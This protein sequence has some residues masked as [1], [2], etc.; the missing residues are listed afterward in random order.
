VKELKGKGGAPWSFK[1]NS[2]TWNPVKEL[3][4]LR[5]M[6]ENK[7][8]ALVES[9]EGIESHYPAREII[10]DLDVESG[11]GIESSLKLL[12]NQTKLSTLWNPVKE[13]KGVGKFSFYAR[14]KCRCGIR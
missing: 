6:L 2:V 11:E 12:L 7:R 4:D 1:F 14:G 5:V 3:K 8:I 13:L 9:G 10:G